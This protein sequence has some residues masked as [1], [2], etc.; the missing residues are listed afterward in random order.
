MKKIKFLN[1]FL[2]LLVL[3]SF[4]GLIA[5]I[6]DF[7]SNN[8]FNYDEYISFTLIIT[9][10]ILFFIGLFF[11]QQALQN[12][13]NKRTFSKKIKKQFTTSSLI[14]LLSASIL[15]LKLF[16][17]EEFIKQSINLLSFYLLQILFA[18]LVL[19]ISEIV[20]LGIELKE[21]NELT[22]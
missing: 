17:N 6:I 7:M 16:I 21:E 15:L 10:D 3:F 5:S 8:Q 22:I 1:G 4:I 12:I 20:V 13:I 2:I 19:A 18:L 14:L 11:L 9:G